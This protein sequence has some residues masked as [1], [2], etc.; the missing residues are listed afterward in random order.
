MSSKPPKG[1]PWIWLTGELIASDAWASLSI[2]ARRVVDFLINEHLSHGGK[3]N[4]ALLAPYRQLQAFGIGARHVGP[5]INEA[6]R[7]GII[8]RRTA[9]G[10]APNTYALTW[11]PLADGTPALDTWRSFAPSEGKAGYLPKG[12]HKQRSDFRREGANGVVPSLLGT[13]E[14]KALSRKTSTRA[15]GFSQMV[16]E[17]KDSVVFDDEP[18]RAATA[19]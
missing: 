3:E 9:V 1:K 11:L 6:E 13:S 10:R 7:A 5:A 15:R 18:A 14:G 8:L 12:R 19:G 2:N 16:E 4:G 17:E